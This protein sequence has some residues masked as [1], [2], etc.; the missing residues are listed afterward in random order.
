MSIG[1]PYEIVQKIKDWLKHEVESQQD[2]ANA[3]DNKEDC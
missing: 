2:V 1:Y 3:K